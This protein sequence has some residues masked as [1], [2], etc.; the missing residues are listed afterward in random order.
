MSETAGDSLRYNGFKKA[1]EKLCCTRCRS[2]RE[3]SVLA[4]S[5]AIDRLGSLKSDRGVYFTST[6]KTRKSNGDLTSEYWPRP[7]VRC[8][9]PRQAKN[10]MEA[11]NWPQIQN[12]CSS[13]NTT[14]VKTALSS[15]W[16]QNIV[17]KCSETRSNQPFLTTWAMIFLS[18][19][20][21]N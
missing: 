4:D 8:V 19:N 13:A 5:D 6:K 17:L 10:A 21:V 14:L 15:T 2:G 7:I 3:H 11:T 9:M 20:V 18:C 12:L 1:Q 16:Q